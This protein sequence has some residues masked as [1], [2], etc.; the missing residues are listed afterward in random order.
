MYK[1][2]FVMYTNMV[3]KSSATFYQKKTTKKGRK[4]RFEKGC[5]Q[6]E[7]LPEHENRFDGYRKNN[8]KIRKKT[9]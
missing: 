7:K 2:F 4:K 8:F 1:L 3:I 6:Y 9:S 5:E